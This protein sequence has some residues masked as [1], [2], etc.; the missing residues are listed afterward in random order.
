MRTPLD[1]IPNIIFEHGSFDW[2]VLPGKRRKGRP[3]Q[4][5]TLQIMQHARKAAG[6]IDH[7]QQLWQSSSAAW[8]ACVKQCKSVEL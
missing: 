5:W 6:G 7:L 8:Q 1:T 3:Q 2:K 4:C